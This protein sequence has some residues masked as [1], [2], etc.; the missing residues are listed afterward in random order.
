MQ[1]NSNPKIDN[2]SLT[3]GENLADLEESSA[4]G[5]L[6]SLDQLKKRSVN[7]KLLCPSAPAEEKAILLGVV[8]SDGSVAYI[9]DKMKVTRE[10]LEITTKKGKPETRF[11]FSSPCIKSGCAQWANNQCSLPERLAKMIPKSD[12]A[13]LPLP[14]CSIRDQCRW[15]DQRGAAACRICPVVV[16]RGNS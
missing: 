15:F 2:M 7:K 8:Q 10:F 14:S 11:R 6:S 16:T 3:T 4:R 5:E 12:T 9:K 13:D 1:N